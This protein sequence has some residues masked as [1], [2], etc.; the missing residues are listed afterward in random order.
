MQTKLFKAKIRENSKI[1]EAPGHRE[2]VLTY[3][4]GS[5]GADDYNEFLKEYFNIITGGKES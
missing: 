1:A 5:I 4:P 2:S 3:A